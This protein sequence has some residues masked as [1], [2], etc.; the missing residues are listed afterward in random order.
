MKYCKYCGRE[1]PM[2]SKFCPGC[3]S[4]ISGETNYQNVPNNN[5]QPVQPTAVNTQ[6]LNKGM[7]V[8]GYFFPLIAYLVNPPEDFARFHIAQGMNLWVIQII[9]TVVTVFVGILISEELSSILN[10]FSVVFSICYIIGIIYAAT[11]KREKLP[12]I[13]EMELIKQR[14]YNK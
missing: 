14:N 11:G 4:Q 9:Y 2:E 13:G 5:Y 6:N 12:I 7:A 10:L 1:V 8:L 3:G